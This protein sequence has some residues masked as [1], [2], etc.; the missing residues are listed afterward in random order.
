MGRGW[1]WG[2][3][4]W[5]WGSVGGVKNQGQEVGVGGAAGMRQGE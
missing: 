1:G 4:H 3:W 5:P 2:R